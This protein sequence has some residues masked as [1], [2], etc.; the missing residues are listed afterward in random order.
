MI[1]S[2]LARRSTLLVKCPF[3]LKTGAP[4]NKCKGY[5]FRRKAKL[6]VLVLYFGLQRRIAN[7]SQHVKVPVLLFNML[8]TNRLQLI[9]RFYFENGRLFGFS[10]ILFYLGQRQTDEQTNRQA[11]RQDTQT[12]KRTEMPSAHYGAIPSKSLRHRKSLSITSQ[13]DK[14]TRRRTTTAGTA[15]RSNKAKPT[16]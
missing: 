10:M 1:E 7:S 16:H 12:D 11:H 13:R 8:F 3:R 4:R 5:R 9:P 6:L 15:V 14:V 2:C